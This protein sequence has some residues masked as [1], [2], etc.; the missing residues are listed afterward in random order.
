MTSPS[1]TT[2]RNR[3]TTKC[4]PP[5]CTN[6]RQ[7]KREKHQQLPDHPRPRSPARTCSWACARAAKQAAAEIAPTDITWDPYRTMTPEGWVLAEARPAGR[8]RKRGTEPAGRPGL[9]TPLPFGATRRGAARLPRTLHTRRARCLVALS[10]VRRYSV[11]PP[12]RHPVRRSRSGR[13]L[14]TAITSASAAVWPNCT[15]STQAPSARLVN[16]SAPPRPPR[17]TLPTRCRRRS[18]LT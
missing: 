11:G 12:S 2:Q 3:L 18:C 1:P 13:R 14:Q 6:L 7:H 4:S 9:A 10:R 15:A 8:S 17:R 5:S 16:T